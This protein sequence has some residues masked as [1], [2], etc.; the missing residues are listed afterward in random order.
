MCF[1]IPVDARP[2]VSFAQSRA[3]LARFGQEPVALCDWLVL[4]RQSK[5]SVTE[6]TISSTS[7]CVPADGQE[8]IATDSVVVWVR[9]RRARFA[10]W[11]RLAPL[12]WCRWL[13][14]C[15]PA[16]DVLD[17]VRG[18]RASAFK[19]DEV[20]GTVFEHKLLAYRHLARL[21]SSQS[22]MSL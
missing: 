19:G 6:P 12:E 15:Q 11:G 14:L 17:E 8:L 10:Y 2:G 4:A 5:T 16:T 21:P 13:R 22:G 3:F 18:G 20:Q 1:K 7:S 9:L